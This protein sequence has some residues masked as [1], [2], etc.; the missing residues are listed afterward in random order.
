MKRLA[1]L[2]VVVALAGA[3]SSSRTAGPENPGT[4][5]GS[6]GAGHH[7]HGGNTGTIAGAQELAVKARS[8][9][10]D[11]STITIK[12]GQAYNVAL[13]AEDTTHDFTVDELRFHVSADRSMTA[14]DGLAPAEP[15]HYQFYCSVPGH[16]DQGMHG[17]LVVE[18]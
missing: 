2:L 1:A 8:F 17:E 12:A 11:P 18:E 5:T 7:A 3:C 6:K 10:F 4:G 13:H 14:T 9:S 16:R 15:G